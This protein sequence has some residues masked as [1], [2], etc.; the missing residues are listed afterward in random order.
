MHRDEVRDPPPDAILLG[1]TDKCPVQG[2]Y[3]P[4]RYITVQ[5]HPEFTE[6][7]VREVSEIRHNGGVFSD[8]MYEDVLGRVGL[9]HDGVAIAKAFVKFLEE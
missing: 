1:S 4:G 9:P 7:I 5:G 6:D 8:D 2:L 3:L